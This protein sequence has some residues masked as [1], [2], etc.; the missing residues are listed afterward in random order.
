MCEGGTLGPFG[1]CVEP[2]LVEIIRHQRFRMRAPLAKQTLTLRNHH[3]SKVARLLHIRA[4]TE[5]VHCCGSV[6][7]NLNFETSQSFKGRACASFMREIRAHTRFCGCVEPQLNFA[8]YASKVAC[9][10]YLRAKLE[11]ECFGG[12]VEPNLK[13]ATALSFKG[14]AC[15]PLTREIGT[16]GCVEPNLNFA[17]S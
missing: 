1:G 10:V 15:A 7:P 17:T 11:H 8:T 4:K 9:A 16:G 14:C 3:A 6:E 2:N 12:C 13:F 5:C